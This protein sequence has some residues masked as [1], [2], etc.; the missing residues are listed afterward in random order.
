MFEIKLWNWFY[1]FI[2]FIQFPMNF[3]LFELFKLNW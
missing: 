3:G 1:N 2:E